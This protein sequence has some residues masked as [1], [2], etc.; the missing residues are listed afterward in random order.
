ML[1]FMYVMRSV[2]HFCYPTR[3][4]LFQV[5]V[6]IMS[7]LT[8]ILIDAIG[9]ECSGGEGA[10]NAALIRIFIQPGGIFGFC[11]TYPGLRFFIAPPSVREKPSWYPRFR[12]V[13][14]RALQQILL[15]RPQ[16]LQLLEDHPGVLDPDGI[17][18]NIMSGVNFVQDLCD[19]AT[20]LMLVPA[21]DPRIRYSTF[22][23]CLIVF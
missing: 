4:Y 1:Y 13:V 21:P 9:D 8:N 23:R 15:S 20:Q 5:T 19:Q 14:L 6:V 18:Y 10:L 17:H 22:L 2:H 7:V 12:P 11:Q 3:P 16:N